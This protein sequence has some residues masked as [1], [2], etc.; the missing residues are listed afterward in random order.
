MGAKKE[1]KKGSSMWKSVHSG[2]KRWIK[3][4]HCGRKK[5]DG[6]V[7]KYGVES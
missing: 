6:A 3:H 2:W 5:K 7:K 1:W 4:K